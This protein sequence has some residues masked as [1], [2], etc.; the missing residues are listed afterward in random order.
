MRLG[1]GPCVGLAAD[2]A[3]T[4]G[5]S[6]RRIGSRPLDD[7]NGGKSPANGEKSEHG[8]GRTLETSKMY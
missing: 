2:A 8:N 5:S 7:Q 6:A 4:G 3:E 1:G